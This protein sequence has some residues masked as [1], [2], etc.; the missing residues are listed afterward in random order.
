MSERSPL[1]M[2]HCSDITSAPLFCVVYCMKLMC[3]L[4]CLVFR[5]Q[6]IFRIQNIIAKDHMTNLLYAKVM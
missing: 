6:P 2:H 3:V 5:I 4:I 1:M